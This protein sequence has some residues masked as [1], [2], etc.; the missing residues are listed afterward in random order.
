MRPGAVPSVATMWR[1]L[2]RRGFI[3]PQP[4]KRPKNSWRRFQ[5]DL[6]NVLAGRHHPLAAPTTTTTSGRTG[7]WPDAQPHRRS[8]LAPRPRPAA[9]GSPS[10][11]TTGFAEIASTRPARSPCATGPSSSTSASAAPTPH[12][13]PAPRRRPA[14][15]RHHRRRRTPPR[16]RHRPH[17]QQPTPTDLTSV[18]DVSRQ[19]SAMSRDI[20]QRRE[21]DSNPR[22]AGPT[23]AFQAC[24]FGRSRIPPRV[25]SRAAHA[26]VCRARDRR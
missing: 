18:H 13:R 2:S 7:H 9:P 16:T 10:P 3:A 11:C 22:W 1:V 26:I 6:P 21:W 19:L 8:T 20:T 5:A 12:P 17:P 25:V 15:P 23:H 4:Q 14:R 24:R